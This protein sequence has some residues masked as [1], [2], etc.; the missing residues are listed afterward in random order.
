[1]R[2]IVVWRIKFLLKLF[3][4]FRDNS[5]HLCALKGQILWIDVFLGKKFSALRHFST[6]QIMSIWL[7]FLSIFLFLVLTYF[8]LNFF[9]FLLH[10]IKRKIKNRSTH[11]LF[12]IWNKI[13]INPI[14]ILNFLKKFLKLP[15]KLLINSLISNFLLNFVNDFIDDS[16]DKIIVLAILSILENNSKTSQILSFHHMSIIDFFCDIVKITIDCWTHCYGVFK[17]HVI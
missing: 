8:L 13:I 11:I 6:D 12:L 3:T 7:N 14:N 15:L 16:H 9:F 2:F 17:K 1:M 4:P 10:K 5:E